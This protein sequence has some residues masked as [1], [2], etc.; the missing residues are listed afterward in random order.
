MLYPF[1]ALS[2]GS[3]AISELLPL[4]P[5]LLVHLQLTAWALPAAP[6]QVQSLGLHGPHPRKRM[7]NIHPPK[8]RV[9]RSSRG[10]FLFVTPSSS[11]NTMQPTLWDRGRHDYQI[12]LG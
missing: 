12:L 9:V 5:P 6:L 2:L 4:L 11:I 7:M 3:G 10:F 8:G 1:P